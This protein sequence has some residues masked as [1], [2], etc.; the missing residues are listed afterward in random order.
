MPC[1][2]LV[3]VCNELNIDPLVWYVAQR[4]IPPKKAKATRNIIRGI[5]KD[6]FISE[7]RYNK[8]LTNVVQVK[9]ASAK[10]TMFVDYTNLNKSCLKDLYLF[11]SIDKVVYNSTKY[12]LLSFM[13]AYFRYNQIPK[14]I[15]D[16]D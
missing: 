9:K 16:K 10:W 14:H 1:I 2:D 8:W 12:K 3:V 5:L 15:V 13:D 7:I 11:S 4:R 6:D